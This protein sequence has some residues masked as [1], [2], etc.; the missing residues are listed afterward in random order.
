VK[1]YLFKLVMQVLLFRSQ[2]FFW[3]K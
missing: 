1:E 3:G 2:V